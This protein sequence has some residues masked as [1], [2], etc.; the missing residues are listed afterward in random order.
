MLMTRARHSVSLFAPDGWQFFSFE[1][2]PPVLEDVAEKGVVARFLFG[3][4]MFPVELD[5]REHLPS[6]GCEI[7][8][9]PGRPEHI[10]YVLVDD[11]QAIRGKYVPGFHTPYDVLSL[12]EDK[13]IIEALVRHFEDVWSGA[14]KVD[15]LFLS[16]SRETLI[17]VPTLAEVVDWSPR[18]AALGANPADLFRLSTRE[19]ESSLQNCSFATVLKQHLHPEHMMGAGMCLRFARC[20]LAQSSV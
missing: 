5:P 19:F 8:I 2:Y 12:G 14:E 3:K 15:V 6:D 16:D 18:I 9:L 11:S 7:R 10:S 17:H 13:R 1:N 20:P 4:S